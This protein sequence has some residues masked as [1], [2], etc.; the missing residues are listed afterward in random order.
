VTTYDQLL[1][2]VI[3]DGIAEVREAYA[4]PEEH[5]KRDGA[6]EGFEACHGKTP[7]QIV[8]LW[9]ESERQAQ[10][11]MHADVSRD[12]RDYWRQRYKMLQIE[13]VLNVISVGLREPLL[14]HLPTARGA[15]K[16]AQIV[17]VRGDVVPS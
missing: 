8:D 16:Y 15:M 4:S 5:H 17:G 11:I 2:R 1:D 6:I 13:W 14:A 3:S 7:A 12:A 9:L 10:Q